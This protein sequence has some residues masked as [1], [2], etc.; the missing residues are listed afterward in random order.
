[1][2]AVEPNKHKAAINTHT[3]MTKDMNE[4]EC[5]MR[6][7]LARKYDVK[8]QLPECFVFFCNVISTNC[9]FWSPKGI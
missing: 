4:W 2:D 5:R 9:F 1:M 7:Y 8:L 3:K 6:K